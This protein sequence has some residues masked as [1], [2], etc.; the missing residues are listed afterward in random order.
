[1]IESMLRQ[2]I[3][4]RTPYGKRRSRIEQNRKDEE[5]KPIKLFMKREEHIIERTVDLN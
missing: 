3:R 2:A 4:I 5:G 1:M